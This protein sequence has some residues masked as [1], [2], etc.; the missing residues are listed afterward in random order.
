MDPAEDLSDAISWYV[1]AIPQRSRHAP[2]P[3]PDSDAI[4]SALADIAAAIVPLQLPA[5]V[6]WLWQTWEVGRFSP[7]PYPSLID[8]GFALE[9]W[10]QNAVEGGDPKTLFPVAYES[11]GFLLIELGGPTE[12]P[13]PVWEY[14]YGDGEYVLRYPSLA[15]LFRACAEATE[16]S[17]VRPPPDDNDRW[18]T[19]V[20]VLNGSAF[21]AIV[22]RHFSESSQRG[23]DRQ[24][25]V[26]DALQWPQRWQVAQGVDD[27][28]STCLGATHTVQSFVADASKTQV[29]GRIVGRFQ[30]Q[31]G[32]GFG[33]DGAAVSFGLFSDDTGSMQVL[34]PDSVL[35]VG[36]RRDLVEV[37]LEASAP[38]THDPI[39]DTREMQDAALRGDFASASEA[40]GDWGNAVFRAAS[41]MPIIRR[42]V[43]AV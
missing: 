33:P 11:H 38:I 20:D 34:L 10:Q 2:G 21:T 4:A 15:S 27:E 39:P 9:S 12:H 7:L 14:H 40:A 18:A 3:P 17:G 37:E 24:V 5:E 16:A 28:S 23:R 36:G 35:D 25:P 1:D 6:V 42:I 26:G 19:Y 8:P 30:V 22:E 43:P 13:A 31:G 41:T 32:G 29:V